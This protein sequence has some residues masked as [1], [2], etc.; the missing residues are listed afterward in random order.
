MVTILHI[1]YKQEKLQKLNVYFLWCCKQKTL[2]SSFTFSIWKSSDWKSVL[3]IRG[4]KQLQIPG[5]SCSLWM[6]HAAKPRTLCALRFYRQTSLNGN[7]GFWIKRGFRYPRDLATFHS[8]SRTACASLSISSAV[9]IQSFN[10]TAQCDEEAVKEH[11]K[12]Q[13]RPRPWGS[14]TKGGDLSFQRM[15]RL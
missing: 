4:Q 1:I 3:E 6:L 14:I 5:V 11:Q 9:F 15:T 12:P 13:F 8:D 7:L 10:S 2:T